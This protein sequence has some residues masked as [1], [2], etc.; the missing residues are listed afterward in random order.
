[1]DIRILNREDAQ[2]VE[3][4]EREAFPDSWSLKSI[5][6]TL[7]QKN[8]V[9]LGAWREGEL[10]GYLF[11][12]CMMDE[13]EI[14][15]IATAPKER[16]KGIAKLLFSELKK[17]CLEQGVDKWMLDVRAGNEAALACY[18]K[19]GFPGRRVSEELLHSSCGGCGAYELQDQIIIGK[20]DSG[21]HWAK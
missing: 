21:S 14:I 13:G 5:E 1:M 2:E 17:N 4:L 11:F 18:R 20:T 7:E 12:S 16:R 15:R 9:N 8:Y 10:L 6:G 3:A 19:L